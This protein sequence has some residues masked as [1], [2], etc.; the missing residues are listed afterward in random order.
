MKR[1]FLGIPVSEEVRSKIIF[2]QEELSSI[3]AGIKLVEP[4][5]LH[6]T[7]KFFGEIEDMKINQIK[8]KIS[9]TVLGNSFS[10]K[11]AGLGCFP[12]EDRI[13]VIWLGLKD[14]KKLK[15]LQQKVD[16]SLSSLFSVEK[17]FVSHLTIARVKF[18]ND[19]QALKQ[20]LEKHKDQEFGN[21]SVDKIV[22]YQSVLG[23]D[24]P[25]YTELEE[26]GLER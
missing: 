4:V 12:D 20:F 24:G 23:K 19:K 2:L 8:E 14:G 11:I 3:N 21:T 25:V 22:L 10:V 26:W 6:F 1:I 9:G 13:N 5:N 17:E 15:E 16:A 18:V 7:L